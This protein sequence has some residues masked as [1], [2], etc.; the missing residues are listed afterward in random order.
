VPVLRGIDE[1]QAVRRNFYSASRESPAVDRAFLFG[2]TAMKKAKAATEQCSLEFSFTQN[3]ALGPDEF[4]GLASVFN[5]PIDAFVP[6][7]IEP[8]AFTKTLTERY[9]NRDAL[10]RVKILFNHNPDVPI[11]KPLAFE[12]TPEGLKVRAKI[13]D[14]AVGRDVLKL[15]RDGVLDSMSIGFDPIKFTYE[16][17]SEDKQTWRHIQEIRLWDVSVVT[18]PANA[19]ALISDVNSVVAFHDLPAALRTIFEPLASVPFEEA[20]V[21]KVLSA[22]N[23]QIVNDAIAALQALIAAAE[24][25]ADEGQALTVNAEQQSKLSELQVWLAQNS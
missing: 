4:E 18:F 16:E 13:S 11:G 12:E 14:T 9:R 25:P 24:P 19:E 15:M 8:G 6:T 20:H 5:V 21:G 2:G 10:S 23:K 7:V 3:P 17:H 1:D 22:K